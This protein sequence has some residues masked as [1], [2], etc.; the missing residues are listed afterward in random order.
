MFVNV[1]NL[2]SAFVWKLEKSGF[3]GYFMSYINFIFKWYSFF[4]STEFV[5]VLEKSVPSI[6][7]FFLTCPHY[8][9]YTNY[10]I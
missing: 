5:E 10:V 1:G 8:V 3:K 4:Q 2:P 9:L 7:S 6:Y